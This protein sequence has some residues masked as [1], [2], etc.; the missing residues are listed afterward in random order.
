MEYNSFTI[1][2]SIIM[3]N[4]TNDIDIRIREQ[5][6]AITFP[7][8]GEFLKSD[9]KEQLVFHK[10]KN[11]WGVRY[12]NDDGTNTKLL[13]FVLVHH[14]LSF[15]SDTEGVILVPI[16]PGSPEAQAEKEEMLETTHFILAKLK[17]QAFNSV[18]TTVAR[19]AGKT[20]LGHQPKNGVFNQPS[21]SFYDQQPGRNIL[22]P[23]YTYGILPDPLSEENP[24]TLD[25]KWQVN[26]FKHTLHLPKATRIRKRKTAEREDAETQ[27][28]TPTP[29]QTQTQIDE[30]TQPPIV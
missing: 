27:T 24:V 13:C 6:R 26:R 19:N 21:F 14:T 1:N 5:A 29:S 12:A 8:F 17:L 16:N 3:N 18:Y 22:T 20:I 2:Q 10:Y 23:A 9:K 25:M 28:P 30:E 7:S 11:S 4:I 15:L